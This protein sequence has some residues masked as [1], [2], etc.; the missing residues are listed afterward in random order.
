MKK[1]KLSILTYSLASGGAERVIS[2]LLS[3]LYQQFDITPLNY[4]KYKDLWW[5]RVEEYYIKYAH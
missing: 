2:I 1:K 5:Q 3:E 4:A